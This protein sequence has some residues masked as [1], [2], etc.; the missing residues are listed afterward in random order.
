MK[1]MVNEKGHELKVIEHIILKTFWEYYVC[2]AETNTNDVKLC[3]VMGDYDELGDVSMSE[4]K[5][6]VI[7]RTKKL[8]CVMPPPRWRWK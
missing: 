3:F 6:Y 8:N 7:T 4:I 2:D 1:T 5:P